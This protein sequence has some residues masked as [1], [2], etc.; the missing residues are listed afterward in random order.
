MRRHPK[1]FQVAPVD[2][3]QRRIVDKD[4]R[5]RTWFLKLECGHETRRRF[6][7]DPPAYAICE[8]CPAVGGLGGREFGRRRA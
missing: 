1:R 3:R 6:I 8:H 2:P 4:I 5:G 7:G